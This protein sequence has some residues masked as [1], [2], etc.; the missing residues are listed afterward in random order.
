M[1]SRLVSSIYFH[2]QDPLIQQP[3]IKAYINSYNMNVTVLKLKELRPVQVGSED[4][5]FFCC[6]KP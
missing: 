3:H 6:Q 4:T 2:R 5:V 1:K